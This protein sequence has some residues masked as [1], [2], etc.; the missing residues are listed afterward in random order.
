MEEWIRLA[1]LDGFNLSPVVQPQSWE[2]IVELLVPELQ[3]RDIY[4][5]DY[6]VPGGTLREN[7]QGKGNCR[8]R[9]DHVGSRYK[10]DRFEFECEGSN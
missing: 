6:E 8:L 3:R 9:E 5:N 2:D 1:D 10:F 4:W 7:V